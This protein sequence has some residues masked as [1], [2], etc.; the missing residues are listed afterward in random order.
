MRQVGAVLWTTR[1]V[2]VHSHPTQRTSCAMAARTASSLALQALV[3]RAKQAP[4]RSKGIDGSTQVQPYEIG[5][6]SS[7]GLL[8]NLPSA[9]T[10]AVATAATCTVAAAIISPV[11]HVD[12]AVDTASTQAEQQQHVDRGELNNVTMTESSHNRHSSSWHRQTRSHSRSGSRYS[13]SRSGSRNSGHLSR[14]GSRIAH[15]RRWPR[16]AKLASEAAMR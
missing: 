4:G 9:S 14:S 2:V 15:Q 1:E 16:H 3:R 11:G 13:G 5:I 8:P 7:G 10:S 12:S 6:R